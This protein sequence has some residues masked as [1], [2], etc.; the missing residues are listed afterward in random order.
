MNPIQAEEIFKRYLRDECTADEKIWVETWYKD[1]ATAS[2]SVPQAKDPYDQR[3]QSWLLLQN[4]VRKTHRLRTLKSSAKIAAAVLV[5]VSLGLGLSLIKTFDREITYADVQNEHQQDVLPGGNRAQLKLS[6]GRVVELDEL[7]SGIVIGK[8]GITYSDGTLVWNG[9]GDG[10]GKDTSGNPQIVTVSTPRGGQYQVTLPDGSKVWL[11]AASSLRYPITFAT[12]SREVELDGEAYFDIVQVEITHPA[13]SNRPT[14][15]KQNKPLPPRMRKPFV[16]KSKDQSIRVF[17]TEFNVSAY[18]DEPVIRTT[19]VSGV[20]EVSNL[21]GSESRQLK[22]GE[23]AIVR[24]LGL[25]VK[26]V[27]VG[28]YVD[29]KDGVIVLNQADFPSLLRQIERWYD[30]AFDIKAR[31]LPATFSGEVPRNV[32]LSEILKVLELNT[33]A[34]FKVDGRRITMTD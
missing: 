12:N 32:N 7:H 9:E 3:E 14:G 18:A 8:E 31:D 30:V 2:I 23:Q 15:L 24:G 11:N 20:V 1:Q 5:L 27:N 4:Q 33:E 28:H 13:L 17:G 29:W 25:E 26:T 16:V 34:K 21:A 6:D 10:A 19:L 22:P